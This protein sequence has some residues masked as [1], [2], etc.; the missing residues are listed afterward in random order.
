MSLVDDLDLYLVASLAD[1]EIGLVEQGI[2]D[3]PLPMDI[4]IVHDSGVT[5][6]ALQQ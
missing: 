2:N 5:V 4:L 3:D 6:A 1:N